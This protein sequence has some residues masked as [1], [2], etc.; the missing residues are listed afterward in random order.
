MDFILG[1]F[2]YIK[3]LGAT[4]M[5]PI[6]ICIMG[7]ALGAGFGK[8]IRAGL[9]VGIGFIG[10]NLVTGLMGSSLGAAVQEMV[11]RFGLELSV[12]DVAG[13]PRPPLHLH[14]LWEW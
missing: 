13:R 12:I 2:N 3:D 10:L 1:I 14:P 6:I 9:T 8:S 5:M 11:S 4:T 7:L